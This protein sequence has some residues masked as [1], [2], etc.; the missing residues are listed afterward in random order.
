MFEDL[1]QKIMDW[2]WR[3]QDLAKGIVGFVLISSAIAVWEALRERRKEQGAQEPESEE[4]TLGN[5][6]PS[7][8]TSPLDMQAEE[9]REEL[10]KI[11]EW[12][13]RDASMKQWDWTRLGHTISRLPGRRPEKPGSGRRLDPS[14][15]RVSPCRVQETRL[16]KYAQSPRAHPGRSDMAR[17]L[18]QS[19]L[20]GYSAE[21]LH[22]R[23]PGET[24]FQTRLVFGFVRDQTTGGLRYGITCAAGLF[25]EDL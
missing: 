5:G 7:E 10:A 8:G 3:H 6:H 14:G 22:Y 25:I 21:C 17:A 2:V 16:G 12:V 13:K 24:P 15:L 20:P 9:K 11:D 23:T 19:G 18:V 1:L 4:D